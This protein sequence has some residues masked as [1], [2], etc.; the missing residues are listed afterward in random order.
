MLTVTGLN[1]F[2]GR[3]QALR[4]VSLEVLDGEI[5]ALIGANGAGKTTLLNS[6][7]G[8]IPA[9]GGQIFIDGCSIAGWPTD[10]IV[11]P[12]SQVWRRQMLPHR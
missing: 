2:Y 9:S 10:R 7:S 8:I 4:E 11:T 5:I 6:I 3:I 12:I 1:T